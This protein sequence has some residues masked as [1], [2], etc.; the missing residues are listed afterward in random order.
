M[1]QNSDVASDSPLPRPSS[2]VTFR[3]MDEGGVLLCS[4]TEV[5]FGLNTLG[6]VI[7]EELA[8]QPVGSRRMGDLVSRL[9]ST[10]PEVDPGVLMAEVQEFLT[11]LV[12]SGLVQYGSAPEA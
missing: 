7:W 5:Y 3:K 1:M 12:E 6:V 11:A 10:Y 8:G 4:K 9:T 2:T